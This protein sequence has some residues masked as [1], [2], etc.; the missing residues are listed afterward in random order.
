MTPLDTIHVT[1]TKLPMATITLNTRIERYS[2]SKE[3]SVAL[4]DLCAATNKEL[5]QDF[6]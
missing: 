2:V 6:C 5:K 1:G 4:N 3:Q